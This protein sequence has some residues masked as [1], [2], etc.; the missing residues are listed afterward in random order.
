MERDTLTTAD[1]NINQ[2]NFLG[3]KIRKLLPKK[4]SDSKILLRL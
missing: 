4:L 1:G 2:S 3:R